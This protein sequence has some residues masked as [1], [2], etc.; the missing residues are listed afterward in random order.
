MPYKF[1]EEEILF[2]TL[3]MSEECPQ[4]PDEDGLSPVIH[5]DRETVEIMLQDRFSTA[6]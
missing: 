6:G 5:F 2:D 4:C 1:R 3:T